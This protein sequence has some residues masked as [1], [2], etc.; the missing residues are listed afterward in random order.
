M[1]C[2]EPLYGG[3]SSAYARVMR[4]L[5]VD[6][7]QRLVAKLATTLRRDGYDVSTSRSGQDAIEMVVERPPDA[8][9]LECHLPDIDGME[10]CRRVRQLPGYVRILMFSRGADVD[11]RVRGLEAGAD[12]YMSKPLI[13]TELRA[14]LNALLRKHEP[15]AGAS[16]L[17]ALTWG[18]VTLERDGYTVSAPG[19]WRELTPTECRLLEVFMSQP[20]RILSNA[21]IG[22]AVWR[23]VSPDAA[24]LRVYV[25]YLRGK[26]R[27]CAAAPLIECVP[28]EGYAL[29]RP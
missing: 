3:L 22:E 29:R 21:E 8:M 11:E 18:G 19:G 27:D 26:L 15:V 25:G 20:E 12:A 7:D 14:R 13:V 23:T 1:N 6:Q 10:I 5:I 16:S 4:T 2:A 9:L 28:G 24:T 17:T